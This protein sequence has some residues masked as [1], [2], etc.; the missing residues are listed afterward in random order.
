MLYLGIELQNGNEINSY[1]MIHFNKDKLAVEV[2][3]NRITMGERAARDVSY[4]INEILCRKNELNMVFAAAP[5]QN[6]FLHALTSDRTIE[7]NRINA[8]HMDEY[9]GLRADS[10]QSFGYYLD[11]HIFGKVPF[12]NVYY[13]DGKAVNTEEECERYGTLLSNTS[14]D[15]V[16]F[17]IGE[18]G[19]IAFNDPHVANFN[20]SALMKV[21]DLDYNC[22]MQQ[23]HDN[24]FANLNDVPKYAYTLTIPMLMS[25]TNMFCIVPDDRKK[26]A[27]FNTVFAPVDEHCPA[28]ILRNKNGVKLYLDNASA[29]LLDLQVLIH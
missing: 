1:I 13:I 26:E 14:I 15:I 24:C 21:V 4:K 12:K 2:H 22:R 7:W 19:H 29:S 17:G 5:S 6:E 11:K 28:T 3:P 8:F 20:D 9:I 18:N 25:A 16:C 27:V 10:P 23:V